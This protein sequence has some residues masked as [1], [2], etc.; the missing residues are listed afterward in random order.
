[1]GDDPASCARCGGPQSKHRTPRKRVDIRLRTERV[2]K[3]RKQE[4]IY[5]GLD[6]EGQGR[7]NHVYNMICASTESGDKTWVLESPDPNVQLTTEEILDFLTQFPRNVRLFTFSF[8]YDI[9]KALTDVDNQ[10]LYKLFR[11]ELRQRL[12]K[13]AFKGP[14]AVPW[15]HWRLNMQGTKFSVTDTRYNR[16]G[17]VIWDV[18]KF[19][20]SKFTTALTL[21][22]VGLKEEIDQMILMKDQRHMFDQLTRE[23][24]RNYCLSECRLMATLA[25]KLVEA[26]EKAE[27]PLKNFYGAGSSAAA[28]LKKMDIRRF[29]QEPPE[30][31]IQAVAQ[32][33]SGGRFDNSHIGTVRGKVRGA[34]ISSAY[35]YQTQF[36]PCLVHGVWKRTI[37]RQNLNRVRVACVRYTLRDSASVDT[38]ARPWGPFPFREKDGSICYPAVSG[39]G[40]VWL[41]EFLEGERIFPNVEFREAWIYHQECDCKP[42]KDM[43][44]YYNE[45]CRIGKEGAGIVLKLASNSVPGKTAQSVGSAPF[46]NY[47]WAGNI[48]SGTRAQVLHALGLHKN[49]RDMLMVA[50]DGILT[51]DM[52]LTLPEPMDTGTNIA[53]RDDKGNMVKKPLGGWE[54]K[55]SER[56]VFFARPGVYFPLNP[57]KEDLQIV[58]GRGVGRGVILENWKMIIDRFESWDRKVKASDVEREGFDK[59]GWPVVRVANVSR[60]CGGK[61]SISRSIGP[62]GKYVY[63]RASG[64]H[65]KGQSG[66]EPGNP[67]PNYGQWVV[68]RVAMSFNPNP[69]RENTKLGRSGT[70]TVRRLPEHIESA[71]YDRANMSEE[72]R[73]LRR[74]VA[75]MDEQPDKDHADYEPE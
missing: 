58:R 24:V 25:R 14:R 5:V 71:P 28:M 26:H 62:D 45:R 39:G 40:W 38:K 19:Y 47:V 16:C 29:M 48:N 37:K 7:K 32:A 27:I 2:Y 66:E 41:Q 64:N 72:T 8:N 42:F 4:R 57:S 36:L 55:D 18:W 30:A 44:G 10:P 23:E 43:P 75:E 73:Q 9:T 15:K 13:D 1:M 34:D 59:D 54:I 35:P 70:L 33:F 56:G 60:F 31:M 46:R 3:P 49:W 22:K 17:F 12:G 68:R 69:K 11:P 65:L 74:F 53:F 63:N 21:W 61:S 51:R 50:T 20:Q 6:G 52:S 67:E